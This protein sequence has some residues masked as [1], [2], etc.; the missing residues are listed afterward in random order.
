MT[1]CRFRALVLEMVAIDFVDVPGT[2]SCAT[3]CRRR[4][5]RAA[6]SSPP[7]IARSRRSSTGGWTSGHP[8]RIAV[9][10]KSMPSSGDGRVVIAAVATSRADVPR[11]LPGPPASAHGEGIDGVRG[12]LA[13]RASR[14]GTVRHRP[15][16]RRVSAEG[17]ARSSRAPSRRSPLR[18]DT[19]M[20]VPGDRGVASV[21]PVTVRRRRPSRAVV[22]HVPEPRGIAVDEL[23]RVIC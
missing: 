23:P 20:L 22:V 16:P 8:G 18:G 12:V 3:C 5:D 21:D 10:T 11:R 19:L 7:T 14:S 2:T 1:T 4:R 9:I 13:I 6:R 17:R 15:W